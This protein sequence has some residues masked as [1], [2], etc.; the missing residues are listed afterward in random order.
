M[1][2]RIQ[3]YITEYIRKRATLKNN[4]ILDII[5]RPVFRLK[6]RRLGD[7]ILS[8]PSGSTYSEESNKKS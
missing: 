3:D 8:L 2:I 5:H 7:W 1:T 4:S 6:T